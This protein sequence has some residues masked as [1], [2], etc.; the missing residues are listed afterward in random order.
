MW[1]LCCCSLSLGGVPGRRE[2]PSPAERLRGREIT[3][4]HPRALHSHPLPPGFVA[5]L[6]SGR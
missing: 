1:G 4:G 6:L 5:E 3:L 2:V